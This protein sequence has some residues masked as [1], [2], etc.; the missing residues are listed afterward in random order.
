MPAVKVQLVHGVTLPPKPDQSVVAEVKWEPKKLQG[1]LLLEVDPGL[2]ANENVQIT[3]MYLPVV[4]SEKGIAKVVL[5]NNL[6][7]TQTLEQGRDIGLVTPVTV[8][9]YDRMSA[10]V[11]M[12][13]RE[14]ESS[15]KEMQR[16]S[17]LQD[18]FTK[19]LQVSNNCVS[20]W[21]NITKSS[22]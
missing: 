10:K 17:K 13:S 20:Y 6:G 9:E 22:V 11:R 2:Q 15:H 7:F 3:S 4:D 8:V 14:K 19:E 18:M 21:K 12:V 1:P 16:K 5:T